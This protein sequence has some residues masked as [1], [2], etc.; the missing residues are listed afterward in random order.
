MILH[1]EMI[2]SQRTHGFP[3]V[4]ISRI[5]FFSLPK[6]NIQ[7]FNIFS[8]SSLLEHRL[9]HIGVT[10]SYAPIYTLEKQW[11]SYESLFFLTKNVCW[12][13]MIVLVTISLF[14]LFLIF[15]EKACRG[16]GGTY[17][18]QFYLLNTYKRH[19]RAVFLR[20]F[21][22]LSTEEVFLLSTW[23]RRWGVSISV[24]NQG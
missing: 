7:S 23:Y 10:N 17:F 6:G 5:H 21:S 18:K 24:R 9:D 4:N 19:W 22:F 3:T 8:S 20:R 1:S 15:R 2:T 12:A 16:V 13:T 14:L 11:M